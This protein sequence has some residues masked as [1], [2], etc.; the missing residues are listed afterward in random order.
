MSSE[1]MSLHQTLEQQGDVRCVNMSGN[2]LLT[3]VH[4]GFVK[5]WKLNINNNKF[6]F[7]K[8]SQNEFCCFDLDKSITVSANCET[9]F[10]MNDKSKNQILVEDME[11]SGKARELIGHTDI[12]TC[13]VYSKKFKMLFSGDKDNNLIKWNLT[14]MSKE[15][16]FE[17]LHQSDIFSLE[18]ALNQNFIV[19]GGKDK[20]AKLIDCQSFDQK[21][22]VTFENSI[23]GITC[24]DSRVY[25]YGKNSLNILE[26]DITQFKKGNMSGCFTDNLNTIY[27][28]K[29]KPALFPVEANGNQ[30]NYNYFREKRPVDE[31]G[32]C[33]GY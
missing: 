4:H 32:K 29:A 27:Q 12:I 3:A 19:T 11:N 26:W 5:K 22:E 15:K 20:T 9:V 31:K 16:I 8:Y 28:Q 30:Y 17:N 2:F 33:V 24:R 14:T 21:A 7:E 10:G 18:L 25:C 13:L 23:Y 1:E 6:Y